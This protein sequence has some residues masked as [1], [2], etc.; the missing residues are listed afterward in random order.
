MLP[1]HLRGLAYLAA[2]KRSL[3]RWLQARRGRSDVE[4]GSRRSTHP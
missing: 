2:G 3:N 4:K 1:A